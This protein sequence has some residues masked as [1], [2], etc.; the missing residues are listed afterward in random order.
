MCP[1]LIVNYTP[2]LTSLEA[3]LPQADVK[4][5]SYYTVTCI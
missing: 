5:S 4:L 2:S 1:E 3:L